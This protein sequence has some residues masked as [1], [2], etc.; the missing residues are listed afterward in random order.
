[1]SDCGNTKNKLRGGPANA[2]TEHEFVSWL[3]ILILWPTADSKQLVYLLSVIEHSNIKLEFAVYFVPD[4][5]SL[6]GT[7]AYS[8][9]PS[10]S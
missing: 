2:W 5:S 9:C 10:S 6:H 8:D 1:M 4:Y 7:N 3:A